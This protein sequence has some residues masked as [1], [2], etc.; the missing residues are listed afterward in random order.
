MNCSMAARVQEASG[1]PG[2]WA[3]RW[4]WAAW[5]GRGRERDAV[6]T[7]GDT[8]GTATTSTA[9]PLNPPRSPLSVPA[10]EAPT[11]SGSNASGSE[12]V[13]VRLN[14]VGGGRIDHAAR[15]RVA[16]CLDAR[17]AD[18]CLLRAQLLLLLPR[19]DRGR[20]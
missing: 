1:I 19:V 10:L 17:G 2:S 20:F 14:V 8:R 16:Q 3:A 6:D 13:R 7:H 4:V 9:A 5:R 18:G 15:R 11:S 12:V